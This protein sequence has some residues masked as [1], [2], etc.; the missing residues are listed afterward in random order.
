MHLPLPWWIVSDCQ[1]LAR[2]LIFCVLNEALISDAWCDGLL[3]QLMVEYDEESDFTDYF[4]D[5]ADKVGKTKTFSSPSSPHMILRPGLSED[6]TDLSI[7]NLHQLSG[8]NDVSGS[9]HCHAWWSWY[10]VS[11]THKVMTSLL[12]DILVEIRSGLTQCICSFDLPWP[13]ASF[14]TF[15]KI[16]TVGPYLLLW[17]D[18]GS[19]QSWFL[20]SCADFISSIKNTVVGW[21]P[22]VL[23]RL[24]LMI[25]SGHEINVRLKWLQKTPTQSWRSSATQTMQQPGTV[26]QRQRNSRDV[27]YKGFPIQIAYIAYITVCLDPIHLVLPS[28]LYLSLLLM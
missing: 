28:D 13:L 12:A 20:Q 11:D 4:I 17:A 22:Y 21:S 5:L 8:V 1:K 7:V 2:T 14:S 9:G 16:S 15:E 19:G 25:L 3:V 27:L 23:C 24:S 6:Y 26:L 10:L 18:E